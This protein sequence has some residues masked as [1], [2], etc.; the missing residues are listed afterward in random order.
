MMTVGGGSRISVALLTSLFGVSRA[1]LAGFQLA[2]FLLGP[3]GIFVGMLLALGAGAWLLTHSRN[4]IQSWLLSTQWRRVPPG[5]NDIPA[6]YP[7]AL[8]EKDGYMA[9]NAQGAAHV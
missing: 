4:N 8:M 2:A 9:L 5:E 6:I 7:D 1:T 3:A